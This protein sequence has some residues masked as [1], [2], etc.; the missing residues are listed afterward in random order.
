MPKTYNKSNLTIWPTDAQILETWIIRGKYVDGFA[1]YKST[2]IRKNMK[3]IERVIIKDW[4][5]KVRR[6]L[7]RN[8]FNLKMY[9]QPPVDDIKASDYDD[10]LI[11]IIL[12]GMYWK[13]LIRPEDTVAERGNK[14]YVTQRDTILAENNIVCDMKLFE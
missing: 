11:G 10:E 7:I 12:E 6:V 9:I 5:T 8:G 4:R 2:S 3:G 13:D 14:M 1:E